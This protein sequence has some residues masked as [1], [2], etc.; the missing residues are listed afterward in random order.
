MSTH[1]SISNPEMLK[2]Q[3]PATRAWHGPDLIDDDFKIIFNKDCMAELEAIVAEQRKAPVPDTGTAA[4]AF[5]DERLPQ[6]HARREAAA[7]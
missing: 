3:V 1:M 4:R 7:R 6:A 2:E 5:R